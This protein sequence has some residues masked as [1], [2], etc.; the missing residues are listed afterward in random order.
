[1]RWVEDGYD[2]RRYVRWKNDPSFGNPRGLFIDSVSAEWL[3][4][5]K[6]LHHRRATLY[7]K[8][9][10]VLLLSASLIRNL[11]GTSSETVHLLLLSPSSPT[12]FP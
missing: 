10:A 1:V 9:C 4:L 5:R 8:V 7:W 12:F 6:V 2:L 3:R 11:S